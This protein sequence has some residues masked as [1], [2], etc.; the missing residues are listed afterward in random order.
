[1]AKIVIDG[2]SFAKK[3]DAI[4]Y[5]L[6]DNLKPVEIAKKVGCSTALVSQTKKKFS[7]VD[8]ASIAKKYN[9]TSSITELMTSCTKNSAREEA[10]KALEQLKKVDVP[11]PKKPVS[12][13]A[14]KPKNK[15]NKKQVSIKKTEPDNRGEVVKYIVGYNHAR[16][17]LSFKTI[18]T[19]ESL[20]KEDFIKSAKNILREYDAKYVY[21]DCIYSD[22]S[23]WTEAIYRGISNGRLTFNNIW[24]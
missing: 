3:N 9:K 14:T 24:K 17:L 20:T 13:K 22:G 1:M 2:L 21:L 10:K 15:P 5:Y 18:E 6:Q 8:R 16:T 23:Q 11:Q 12:K 4:C 7:D 19:Y